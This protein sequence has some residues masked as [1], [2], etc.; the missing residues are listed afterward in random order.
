MVGYLPH[1]ALFYNVSSTCFR[2]VSIHDG[3]FEN[4]SSVKLLVIF[5]FHGHWSSHLSYPSPF[6]F[7]LMWGGSYFWTYG[8]DFG[9]IMSINFSSLGLIISS[10]TSKT[11]LTLLT[12]MI[13]LV[14]LYWMLV[15]GNGAKNL[16]GIPTNDP[17]LSSEI[18]NSN[19]KVLKFLNVRNSC[20]TKVFST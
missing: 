7:L 17:N 14:S 4:N 13:S 15:P 19:S 10:T 16:I 12:L 2:S 20:F 11:N 8:G 9:S 5:G 1:F 3:S 18:S 6:L